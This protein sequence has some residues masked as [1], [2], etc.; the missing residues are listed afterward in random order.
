[1]ELHDDNN[2]Y[3]E[4]LYENLYVGLIAFPVIIF[5]MICLFI[6]KNKDKKMCVIKNCLKIAY[7]IFFILVIV[8][9]TCAGVS[10]TYSI[11][12]K[13]VLMLLSIIY[14]L[15]YISIKESNK[16][17]KIFFILICFLNIILIF[18][19]SYS[20]EGLIFLVK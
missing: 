9:V 20:G 15:K 11:E 3:N 10:E 19:I 18:P 6:E 7:I 13:F 8:N 16:I 5:A 4:F 2:Y 12:A 17:L 1:M 14:L